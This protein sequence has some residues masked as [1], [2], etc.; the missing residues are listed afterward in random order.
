MRKYFTYTLLSV[1]M[2]SF[3]SCLDIF[4]KINFNQDG[5]GEYALTMSFNE[6]FRKT[7]E[8]SKKAG[9]NIGDEDQYIATAESRAHMSTMYNI[10]KELKGLKGISDV[11]LI[12]ENFEYGYKYK[13]ENLEALNNAFELT[14][15]EYTTQK[16]KN[17][18]L[19]TNKKK[20]YQ[21]TMNYI[22]KNKNTIIR[23][24]NAE[25]QKVFY[26]NK[27]NDSNKGMA[28][29]LDIAYIFQDMNYKM[30]YTF[31]KKIKRVNNE[32]AIIDDNTVVVN[33]MPFTYTS[34]DLKTVQLNEAACGQ[35]IQIELR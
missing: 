6:A 13:F 26:M 8:E 34:T 2:L 17:Y 15:N 24:Q 1:C 9:D 35:T 27:K 28:G 31:D 4:E 33:C 10:V 3:T 5:S 21:P 23:H 14:S 12:E 20:E 25:L 29:G 22:E 18:Y 16:P 30:V 11:E 7:L 19:G 32:A